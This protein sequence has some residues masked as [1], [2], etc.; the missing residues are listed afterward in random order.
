MSKGQYNKTSR[1]ITDAKVKVPTGLPTAPRVEPEVQQTIERLASSKAEQ[2]IRMLDKGRLVVR[3]ETGWLLAGIIILLLATGAYMAASFFTA[4]MT[5]QRLQEG[6]LELREQAA[7]E[8]ARSNSLERR[9]VE[10]E[11]RLDIMQGIDPA[12]ADEED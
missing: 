8:K 11:T 4:Q 2:T 9:I 10:L 7:T 12:K 3:K 6:Q 1:H 5:V